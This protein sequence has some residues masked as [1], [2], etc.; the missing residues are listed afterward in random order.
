[1]IPCITQ[2][3]TGMPLPRQPLSLYG[4]QRTLAIHGN[5]RL[6]RAARSAFLLLMLFLLRV[7][8]RHSGT[9]VTC[10][11]HHPSAILLDI[12]SSVVVT[13]N[14]NLVWLVN[15]L[16]CHMALLTPTLHTAAQCLG[17][18]RSSARVKTDMD[19]T[20]HWYGAGK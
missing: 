16:P 10:F 8:I 4:L 15:I 17:F 7:R 1:M 18:H 9:P 11:A 2:C 6:Q 3:I 19:V 5:S 20:D 13:L 12:C 14:A